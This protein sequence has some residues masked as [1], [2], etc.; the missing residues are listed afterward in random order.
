[1][2]ETQLEQV[3]GNLL[4][5][6]SKFSDPG[7]VISLQV[8]APTTE[9]EARSVTV[10]VRDTGVGIDA[11]VLP[12]VFD[13]FV[14][15]DRSLDRRHGG[16][17]IGLTLVKRLVEL[18][19]GTVEAHS[20]GPQWGSEFIVQLPVLFDPTPEEPASLRSDPPKSI[21]SSPRRRIL[22]V[23]DHEDSVTMMAVLLRSKGYDVATARSGA[24]ALEI[25][26]T[27]FNYHLTKAIAPETLFELLSRTL[28]PSS[29]PSP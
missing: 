16:L 3:F 4:N 8:D 17:G 27:G 10:R 11:A 15:E 5:N 28:A 2:D 12:R 7:T 13:L 22:V 6:A 19:G 29:A 21:R 9:N 23:D 26:S 24:A 20:E 18:H 1:V 14:Q 25:A